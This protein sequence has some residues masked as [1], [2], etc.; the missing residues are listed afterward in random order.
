[1]GVRKHGRYER[2]AWNCRGEERRG[3]AIHA[4]WI[5]RTSGGRGVGEGV[6]RYDG[7][8]RRVPKIVYSCGALYA[9]H[10]ER[11]MKEAWRA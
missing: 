11:R 3:Q 10:T 6:E 1:M 4:P 9:T 2:Q 8:A 7:E 5:L